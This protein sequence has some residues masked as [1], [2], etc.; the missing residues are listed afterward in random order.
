M[1]MVFHVGVH[2][3]DGDRLLKT[4]LRNR[5]WLLNHRTEVITPQHHRG[6]FED[7]LMSLNGGQATPAMVQI[8][9]DA[10]LE[11]ED[12]QRVLFSSPTFMGATGRAVSKEG[13]YTQIGLRCAALANLFPEAETEFFVAI[14]NPAT[15]IPDILPLFAGGNYHTLM[16]GRHPLDLRWSDA[17]RRLVSAAHGRRIVIWCHEDVPLIWPEIVRLMADMPSDAPLVGGMTYL[18]ELLTDEGNARLKADIGDRDHLTIAQRR[19][20]SSQILT[21]HARPEGVEMQIDLPGWTQ[22]IVDEMTRNYRADVGEIAVL[23]GVEF[24]LPTSSTLE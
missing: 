1:Q 15:L 4:L 3:T 12:P 18:Q 13:L 16:Q 9:L 22:E 10:I 2:G 14:R 20:I 17:I 24:I 6:L 8:M 11:T 7:A 21:E 23:P 19:M 5:N